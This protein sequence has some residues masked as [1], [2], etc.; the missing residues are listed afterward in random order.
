MKLLCLSR[1]SDGERSY[2]AGQEFEIEDEVGAYLQR[3]SPESFVAG[4]AP[5]QKAGDGLPQMKVDE[6]RALAAERG[7]DISEAKNKA[8]I[9]AALRE[10]AMASQT[11][12]Q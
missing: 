8:E 4:S 11:R 7:V 3:C 5:A 6:L 2:A 12:A 9:I 1:F 10:A